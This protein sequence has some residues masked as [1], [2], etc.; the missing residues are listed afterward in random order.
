MSKLKTVKPKKEKIRKE[1]S[2]KNRKGLATF[3]SVLVVAVACA[4][5][6]MWALPNLPVKPQTEQPISYQGVVEMWNV[7]SFEG[8]VGSREGWL[9]NRAAKFEAGNKG[10]FV[11]VTTLSVE[12]VETKLAEGQTFDM[13]C[14]S[15]GVGNLVKEQLTA[16]TGSVG[17]IKDNYLISG[18]LEGSLY[19]VPIYS[20]AYCLFARTEQLSEDRLLSDALTAKFTR[21]IGKNTIELQP[22]VTGFTPY[23]S[24]L[25]ALALSGGK[26]KASV[27]ED[28]TQYQAYE[29]FV[30]NQTAVTLLGTQRDMYRL[31]QRESNGKI[32]KLAFAP[33]AG[34]TDLV[35]YVA[36][37][38]TADDK[39][40]A[41]V[42]FI[43]YLTSDEAQRSL[44]NLSL[45][46]VLD[47]TFFTT[48]RY[49]ECEGSLR[50]AYVPNV[51][52]DADAIANQRKTAKATLNM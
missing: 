48:D 44:V 36:I 35:Q 11:H 10:L 19:A 49:V 15:R 37:S 22:L 33:L 52:G 2:P 17:A 14:F 39:A 29:K 23:N 9:T 47:A 32:D 12:Q 46:S 25:S 43:E 16:Y 5:L 3:A 50:S 18:Q 4:A 40:E 31:S 1:R 26:G 8:G 28:V 45:F 41:C 24:P 38:Q 6:L 21:K 13:I 42:E 20:G 30:A 51:F 34:Y 27:S 7:E